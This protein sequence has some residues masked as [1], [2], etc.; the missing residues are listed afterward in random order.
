V[1]IITR[2]GIDETSIRSKCVVINLTIK[3]IP[4]GIP[5]LFLSSTH[6]HGYEKEN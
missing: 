6:L 2:V 3:S 5:N 1:T 4:F